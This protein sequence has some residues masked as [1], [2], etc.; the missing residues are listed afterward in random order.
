MQI[1]RDNLTGRSCR[2]QG[3]PERMAEQQAP[4]L[5]PEPSHPP[6]ADLSH[7]AQQH[8]SRNPSRAASLEMTEGRHSHGHD[9][10]D[11]LGETSGTRSASVS[12]KYNIGSI[13]AMLVKALLKPI[14]V[15]FWYLKELSA[16]WR[17][18][19]TAPFQYIEAK[20]AAACLA[21]QGCNTNRTNEHP[22]SAGRRSH[23]TRTQREAS[24]CS[25]SNLLIVFHGDIA[26]STAET[27]LCGGLNRQGSPHIGVLSWG[28]FCREA[29]TVPG[30]QRAPS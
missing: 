5:G 4:L 21:D 18:C 25:Q 30:L 16:C 6:Q 23:T 7:L 24:S 8:P 15:K 19:C 17:H 12:F 2:D 20:I 13:A 1:V 11:V 3:D 26:S 10:S 14:L 29:E 28:I 9:L 27:H 22:S